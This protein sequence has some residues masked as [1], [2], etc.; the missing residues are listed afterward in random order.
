[1]TAISQT[2]GYLFSYFLG[3]C[4]LTW[5]YLCLQCYTACVMT[6]GAPG[7]AG[8][9][10]LLNWGIREGER[11]QDMIYLIH[12]MER[13]RERPFI[14]PIFWKYCDLYRQSNTIWFWL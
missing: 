8:F 6:D 3:S 7:R 14:H 2:Q 10:W 5:F 1:M 12:H 13:W 4:Y 9:A 11:A